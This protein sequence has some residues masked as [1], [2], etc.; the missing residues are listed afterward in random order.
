[1]LAYGNNRQGELLRPTHRQSDRLIAIDSGYP[2][3][4]E[5]L[6]VVGHTLFGL[7]EAHVGECSRETGN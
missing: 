4:S 1:M 6:S 5:Y 3:R 2:R 7:E